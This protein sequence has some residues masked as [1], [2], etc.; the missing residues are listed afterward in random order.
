[1]KRIITL[2]SVITIIL[3]PTALPDG[4]QTDPDVKFE[5]EASFRT[6]TV[7][8]LNDDNEPIKNLPKRAFR[9]KENNNPVEIVSVIPVDKTGGSDSGGSSFEAKLLK[10]QTVQRGISDKYLLIL[11]DFWTDEEDIEN[12]KKGLFDFLDKDRSC[13]SEFA[14]YILYPGKINRVLHFTGDRELLKKT[15][16]RITAKPELL[17]DGKRK[18]Q[19]GI[20]DKQQ[21]LLLNFVASLKEVKGR[22][23]PIIFTTGSIGRSTVPSLTQGRVRGMMGIKPDFFSYVTSVTGTTVYVVETQRIRSPRRAWS[24][25]KAYETGR[26]YA[27]PGGN[28][29]MFSN[30]IVSRLGAF[31][32]W[33][34]NS[35]GEIY[36]DVLDDPEDLTELL[37]EMF[38]LHSYYYE[39]TYRLPA[40]T[41]GNKPAVISIGTNYKD[42]ESIMYKKYIGDIKDLDFFLVK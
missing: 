39:I 22:K 8:V 23:F 25:A 21:K 4:R 24:G 26:F 29:Q 35:G 19:L 34:T 27:G 14:L 17:P 40:G 5:I 31:A 3:L 6:I 30:N 32:F 36:E 37:E 10:Q 16:E 28:T 11:A 33:A 7:T 20:A 2:L 9:I 41:D 12:L 42:A 15:I 18:Y 1:M 38:R 13:C